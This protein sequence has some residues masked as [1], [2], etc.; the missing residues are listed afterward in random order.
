MDEAR[1][2]FPLRVET[3]VSRLVDQ[4]V[5]GV[6]TTTRQARYY[7]IHVLGATAAAERGLER[8]EAYELL[9]RLEVV[10]AAIYR[11]HDPHRRVLTV[12]HGQERIDRF[13]RGDQLHVADGARL[14]TGMSQAGFRNVY[15]GVLVRLGLLVPGEP[16]RPTAAAADPAI[17]EGL[18]GLLEFAD[19]DVLEV[20][21][22][23]GASH[24]CLC[25]TAEAPDGAWLRH[26]M[27][28]VTPA[29][30]RAGQDDR[31][32]QLTTKMLLGALSGGAHPRAE[33]AFRRAHGFGA[34]VVDDTTETGLVAAA[35]RGAILRNY[36][37]TA[38]R[39]MWRWLALRLAE[40]PMSADEL[41][42]RLARAAGDEP[43]RDFIEA[44]PPR[45]GSA[46]ELL[47]AEEDLRRDEDDEP[48]RHLRH[49]ALGAMRLD[50][51]GGRTLRA[52]IGDER[53]DLGPAWFRGELDRYAAGPLSELAGELA[54]T[55]VRRAKRVAYSKMEIRDGRVWIPTRLHELGD[56]LWVEGEEGAGDVS[57]R[58]WALAEVLIGLGILDRDPEGLL[59]V[60]DLG[61]EMRGR[62]G[63]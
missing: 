39:E 45:S 29:E 52:F 59:V 34:P 10:T 54:H 56:K 61:E 63:D 46:G 13:I 33:G 8:E 55:L 3:A 22:L 57:L 2:R 37:V 9:R 11:L 43:V 48:R 35:W 38:W 41:A 7:A 18:D 31:H 58:Q 50:D 12:A 20:S 49:L 53:H 62:L 40:E 16:P 14:K 23:R 60:T 26:V 6:I 5:P 30:G 24:L 44:L 27:F 1:G 21:V 19:Q 25:Q 15:T 4:L 32:R 47:A 17:A 28:G 51:L 36:S 42:D